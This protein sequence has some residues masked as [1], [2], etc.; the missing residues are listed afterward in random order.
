[1][2]ETDTYRQWAP[3]P[4][5]QEVVA[6]CSEQRVSAARVQRVLPDGRADLI[7]YRTG[8]IEVVGRVW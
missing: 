8:R 2:N 7:I 5:G 6:C 3:P 4:G 1:L